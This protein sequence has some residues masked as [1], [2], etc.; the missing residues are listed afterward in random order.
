MIHKIDKHKQGKKNRKKGRKFE[1][2]I[3]EMLEH[4][5][6]VYHSF[7]GSGML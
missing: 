5:G 3:R 4:S 1:N 2:D 6:Y 7:R